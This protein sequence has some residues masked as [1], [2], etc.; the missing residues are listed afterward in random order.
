MIKKVALRLS[1]AAIVL[2]GLIAGVAGPAHATG[3]ASIPR[4]PLITVHSISV[5]LSNWSPA[6]GFGSRSP[7]WYTDASGIVHL[8][9]AA[10]QILSSGSKAGLL[11]TLPKAARPSRN[12]F[13]IVHTFAGTYADVGIGRNGQIGLIDPRP[14]AVKDYSFVSLEGITF[15]RSGSVHAISVN[16]SNWTP[17]AGF[18]SRSPGWYIDGSGIV[19]L[20]GAAKRFSSAGSSANVLGTL[21]PAAR[22]SRNVYVVVHTWAG[23][24]ADVGIGKNGQIGMIGAR[25]P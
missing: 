5:N 11:G 8:Q 19:H 12:V 13:V 14:P 1:A 21:P 17:A 6:A 10:K 4:A 7:G 18:G 3:V 23:T 9:G 22:P 16:L 15:K 25:P 20:Q 2:S 24:Y